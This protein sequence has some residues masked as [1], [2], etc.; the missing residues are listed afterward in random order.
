MAKT[1]KEAAVTTRN[2]RLALPAGVH[3]RGIDPDVHLGYRKGKRGGVW[4]V[5][6]RVGAGYKQEKIGTADDAISAGTLDYLAAIKVAREIVER[7]RIEAKAQADGPPLTVQLAVEEYVA[8]RD[9]RD[10]KRAGR[11]VRSDAS[12]RLGRHVTGASARG[13]QKAIPAAKL[14]SVALHKLTEAD[15]RGWLA[16]LPDEFKHATLDR[17]SG[18]LKAALNN[19]YAENRHRLDHRLPDIIKNGLRLEQSEDESDP[20]AR[21][22]QILTDAEVARLLNAVKE[23]DAEQDWDGDLFRLI[24]VMTATGA[25]FS[26]VARMR[27]ADFQLKAGRLV[28]PV[29]RKGRGGKSGAITIPVGSDV[30]DALVGATSGRDADAPLLERWRHGQAPG[31]IEWHRVGRAAWHA[32]SEIARP[33]QAARER[34]GM[35]NVIPYALRHTSIVRGIRANLPIRLVAALHDTSVGMIEAH[36]SRWIVDGL[37]E[38]ARAAVVPLV[39]QSKG[40]RVVKLREGV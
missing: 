39:P 35:P 3:W 40:A 22:N 15:L 25:R 13:Q 24:V 38:M 6:W 12:R 11:V 21:E 16:G 26:Q 33:W 20:I 17:L 28:V 30:L 19:A 4:L 34:A 5:R 27:V 29:S 2:A 9:F 36:Y 1:L 10:S 18:D 32:N 7:K 23:V 14:A 31:S 37:E 8:M